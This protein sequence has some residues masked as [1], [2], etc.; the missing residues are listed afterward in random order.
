MKLAANQERLTR[1]VLAGRDW[2]ALAD[3]HAY[4]VDPDGRPFMLPGMGAV[5]LGV[6]AATRPPDT[7][8]ITWNLVLRCVTGTRRLT[9]RSNS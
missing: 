4:R 5:T 7:R 9:T 2:P 1:Q 8:P 6:H 3:R